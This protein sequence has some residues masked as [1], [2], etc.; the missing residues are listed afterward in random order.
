MKSRY[1]AREIEQKRQKGEGKRENEC[2]RKR[3]SEQIK[4]GRGMN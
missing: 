4:R 2:K 1:R 3:V